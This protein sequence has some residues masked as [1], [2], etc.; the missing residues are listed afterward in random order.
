M[1]PPVAASADADFAPVRLVAYAVTCAVLLGTL[2]VVATVILV[3]AVRDRDVPAAF[4]L[5][6]AGTGA[7]IGLAAGAAWRLLAPIGSVY[8][9]GGLAIVSAFAT[10][11]AMLLTMPIHTFL[12][13]RGLLALAAACAIGCLLLRRRIG[14]FPG[15]NVVDRVVT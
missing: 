6:L 9:R 10:I 8:R 2:V 4:A 1:T 13:Q 11:V 7:G 15:R 5:L 12:G 3:S 14:R